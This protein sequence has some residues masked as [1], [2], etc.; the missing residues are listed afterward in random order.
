ME[1]FPNWAKQFTEKYYSQTIAMFV[2]TGNVHDLVPLRS[3]NGT[4]F[5]PL[6]VFLNEAMFGRRDIVLTYDR[7]YGLAFA[8]PDMQKD[9]SRALEGYDSFHGTKFALGLS[10]N[11]DS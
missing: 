11:P 7:G 1:G 2:L 10:R 3:S 4:R 5:V 6:N 9:F 8:K